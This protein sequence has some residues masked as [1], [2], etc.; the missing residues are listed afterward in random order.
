MPDQVK[1]LKMSRQSNVEAKDCFIGKSEVGIQA[2]IQMDIIKI[3]ALILIA[4]Y[5]E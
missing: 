5:R 3:C 1:L 2:C 4:Q